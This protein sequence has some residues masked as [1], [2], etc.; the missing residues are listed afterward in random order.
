MRARTALC[1]REELILPDTIRRARD[2]AILPDTTLRGTILR[3]LDL[4]DFPPG[5]RKISGIAA[6]IE[7]EAEGIFATLGEMGAMDAGMAETIAEV[8]MTAEGISATP[9]ETGKATVETQVGIRV[10]ETTAPVSAPVR[11]REECTG[12]VKPHKGMAAALGAA[13]E[14]KNLTGC[15]PNSVSCLIVILNEVKNLFFIIS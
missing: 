8:E 13:A 11:A 9:K 5:E 1:L 2:R 14:D 6:K 7:T 12:P 4:T 10:S 3:A 15:C